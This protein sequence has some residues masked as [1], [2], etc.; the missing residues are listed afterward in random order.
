MKIFLLFTETPQKA[1]G[2]YRTFHFFLCDLSG[3]LYA[4]SN[5][6]VLVDETNK[7]LFEDYLPEPI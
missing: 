4:T 2:I 3:G 6:F 1:P 7:K 5:H